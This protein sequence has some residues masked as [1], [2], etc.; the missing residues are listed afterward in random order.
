M[1]SRDLRLPGAFE[2]HRVS[3][4]IL[5]NHTQM[6]MFSGNGAWQQMPSAD[7]STHKGQ[8]CHR[9]GVTKVKGHRD[10]QQ[11]HYR[12][13]ERHTDV[14][15]S[16]SWWVCYR[17]N[18]S[19]LSSCNTA[20]FPQVDNLSWMAWLC[21]ITVGWKQKEPLHSARE[22]LMRW[23]QVK[24]IISRWSVFKCILL[25]RGRVD[26]FSGTVST[27][28]CSKKCKKKSQ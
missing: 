16:D 28:Y 24:V 2:E 25:S 26:G 9:K 5:F 20:L 13:S 1:S 8:A 27:Q 4:P 7:H 14:V 18:R 17:H 19:L 11:S 10:N 22:K 23:F 6:D 15:I 3:S 21:S 12:G